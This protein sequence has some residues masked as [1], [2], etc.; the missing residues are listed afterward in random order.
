MSSYRNKHKLKYTDEIESVDSNSDFSSFPAARTVTNATASGS[1]GKTKRSDYIDSY[2]MTPAQRIRQEAIDLEVVASNNKKQRTLTHMRNK[3]KKK[4]DTK[5]QLLQL[6]IVR[7]SKKI[8]DEQRRILSKN[9]DIANVKNERL[10][11]SQLA[12]DFSLNQENE[13]PTQTLIPNEANFPTPSPV[14]NTGAQFDH[15]RGRN[16]FGPGQFC[17][18]CGHIYGRFGIKCA[19]L[20]YRD[21]CLQSVVDYIEENGGVKKSDEVGVSLAY[22]DAFNAAVKKDI[23]TVTG[24]YEMNNVNPW[25]TCINEGSYTQAFQLLEHPDLLELMYSKRCINVWDWLYAG[26][27]EAA[28]KKRSLN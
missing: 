12:T 16:L 11:Q 15:I 27:E 19:E 3:E 5:Q 21:I 4:D 7:E 14:I 23:L 6:R 2:D 28:K 8:I 24:C 17:S 1:S 22:T 9:T 20:Q 13:S 18:A 25:P 26:E 10:T